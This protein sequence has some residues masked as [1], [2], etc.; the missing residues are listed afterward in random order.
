MPLEGAII[1]SGWNRGGV[2]IVI[3]DDR[4]KANAAFIAAFNPETARELLTA[5][6]ERDAEIERLRER[7]KELLGA[8]T[9][10]VEEARTL[11]QA[12]ERLRAVVDAAR[13]FAESDAAAWAEELGTPPEYHSRNAE[14][15]RR[16][17]KRDE[18]LSKL[19]AALDKDKE[20]P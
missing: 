17:R 11:R 8:N 13:I 6:D 7:E 10:R 15:T 3:A 16:R 4:E 20:A 2:A 14:L 12:N 9:E 18:A 19:R 1:G 5:L